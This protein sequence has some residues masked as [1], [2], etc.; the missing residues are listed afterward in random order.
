M[1]AILFVCF[2]VLLFLGLP[3]AFTLGGSSLLA[4]ALGSEMDLAIV[5]Q[6]IFSG[7]SGFTLMAIPFFVLAGNLM[8]SGGISR[9]LI[10]FCNVM[11]GHVSG[12]LAMVAVVACGFFAA[13][14]GS[15]AATAAAIGAII[16]P[17]M[18]NHRYERNFAAATVA[19]SAELG[20]IIPPSIGL[21]MYGVAAEQSIGDL[22]KAGLLPGVFICVTLMA[23]AHFMAKKQGFVPSEKSTGKQ[24]LAALRKAVLALFMPVMILGS[25][26]GGLCTATEAAVLAVVYGFVVGVF[27][28]REIRWKDLPKILL[29]SCLTA[30]TVLV[31]IGCSNIFG[32]VLA[33]QSVPQLVANAFLGISGSKYV[34]LLLVNVLLLVGMFCEAGSA[35]VILAPLLAP[36]AASLGIDLVHFGIIMMANLAVGMVTPPVGVNLYVVCD[37]AKVKIEGMMR[38]LLVFFAV[39]ILDLLV[40]TF[41][42]QLSLLLPHLLA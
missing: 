19:S 26:Y 5:A 16:I 21:I 25:I 32:W 28:Y 4:I 11:L 7:S 31:I 13:I 9:R 39:L 27:V 3:I 40:I 33:K 18:L 17:E 8:S 42:P 37:S 12:G 15:S 2:F 35:M 6:R 20:V 30:A 10:N 1:I 23:A 36:V 34:F 38:Y 14:S 22:F 29:D 24:K 41:V